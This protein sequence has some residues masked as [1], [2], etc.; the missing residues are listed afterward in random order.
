LVLHAPM[1]LRL[2]L[3]PLVYRSSANPQIDYVKG[4]SSTGFKHKIKRS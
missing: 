1:W 4:T 3:P 2:A